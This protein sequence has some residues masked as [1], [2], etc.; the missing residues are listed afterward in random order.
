MPKKAKDKIEE[1]LN[2]LI[3]KKNSE[4][5][6]KVAAKNVATKSNGKTHLNQLK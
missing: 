6:K 5:A 2:V 1:I 3:N 4:S